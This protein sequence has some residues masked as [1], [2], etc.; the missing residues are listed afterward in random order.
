MYYLFGIFVEKDLNKAFVYYE[1][2]AK[3][4]SKNAIQTY[5]LLKKFRVVEIE[6]DEI[7][8]AGAL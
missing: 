5:E 8:G 3:L 1:Q 7:K 2:A 4:G 6:L